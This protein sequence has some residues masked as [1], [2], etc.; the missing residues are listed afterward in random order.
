MHSIKKICISKVRAAWGRAVQGSTVFW[1]LALCTL[2]GDSLYQYFSL[3]MRY[4]N[5]RTSNDQ[6]IQGFKT[7]NDTNFMKYI[8]TSWKVIGL[9]I[10]KRFV[11]FLTRKVSVIK[12][13][14]TG[15]TW[16]L[17]TIFK[18]VFINWG[19]KQWH[20]LDPS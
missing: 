5:F 11:T 10:W 16:H 9:M 8:P 6:R 17:S 1:N 13:F 19:H 2:G 20:T 4:P 15:I 14:I 12:N 3:L 18:G 7:S